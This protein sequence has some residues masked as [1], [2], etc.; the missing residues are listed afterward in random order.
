MG[1]EYVI[2][3]YTSLCFSVRYTAAAISSIA[4]NERVGVLDGNVIRVLCRMLT[5]GGDITSKKVLDHLWKLVDM[6]IHEL[7]PGDFNQVRFQ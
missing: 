2:L 4:Y 6:L 1:I 5:I 3:C 7:N